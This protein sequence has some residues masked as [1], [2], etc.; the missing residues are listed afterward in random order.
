MRKIYRH[1]AAIMFVSTILIM[2]VVLKGSFGLPT[3]WYT[4]FTYNVSENGDAVVLKKYNGSAT[5]VTIPATVS[6]DGN[7]YDVIVSGGTTTGALFSNNTTLT[8]VTFENGVKADTSLNYL[9]FG[10]SSLEEIVFNNFDTSATTSMHGMFQG[11]SSLKNLDLSHLNT[12]NV[13]DM[14]SMFQNCSGLEELNISN[15]NTS[16]VTTMGSMFNGCSSLKNL[17]VSSFNTSNVTNMSSMFS[18]VSSITTLDVSNFNTSNVT[19]M[20]GMFSALRSV[21][22]L[23]LSNFN[24]SNVTTMN[25]MFQ[26]CESLESVN[27]SSFNTSNV[28]SMSQMFYKCNSLKTLDLS[29]FSTSNVTTM[30]S[31]FYECKAL[32]TLDMSSFTSESLTSLHNTFY[33]TSNLSKIHIGH[34]S[35]LYGTEYDKEA[36]NFGR[37]MW[38]RLEDGKNYE[39]SERLEKSS[40]EDISGTYVFVSSIADSMNVKYPVQYKIEEL[41]TIDETYFS[42]DNLFMMRNNGLY[43]KNLTTASTDDYVV[44]GNAT[45]L[46]KN[47]V[48]DL[49]NNSYHLKITVDNIHLYD[50]NTGDYSEP[51][52]HS[53]IGIANKGITIRS[54]SYADDFT[55]VVYGKS[56]SKYDVT[57]EIVD[58]AGVAQEGS[59]IFSVRD[60]DIP[61]TR[62]KTSTYTYNDDLGWGT[63]SEGIN[64]I[65]GFDDSTLKTYQYSKLVR[66]GNRIY[67]NRFDEGSEFSEFSIKVDAHKFK[68]AWTGEDCGTMTIRYYQPI[69]VNIAKQDNFNHVLEGAEL[70]LYTIDNTLV[71][72]W[73]STSDTHKLFLNAGHYILKEKT[74]PT[75]Y[76]KASD[77]EF[78][79]DIDG[80][81]VINNNEDVEGIILKD[82]GKNVK[83]IVKYLV[84]GTNEELDRITDNNKEFGSSYTSS[85]KS[86]PG[87]VLTR[88]PESETVVLD[89]DETVLTYYYKK[90]SGGV[91]EKHINE[92][93]GAILY[94][95]VHNGNVGDDYNISS[96]TFEGLELVTSRLPNNSV[97]KMQEEIIEVIYYY[98]EKG[99]IK[100][101]YVDKETNEEISPSDIINGYVNDD[102]SSS[103]KD[104]P[105][106][107]YVNVDGEPIGKIDKENQDVIY[108]YQRVVYITTEVNGSGG[109]ISGDETVYYHH[110][111]T[112]NNIIIE[113]DEE[114]FINKITINGEEIKIT[115]D[116]K[117]VLANFLN[118]DENKHIVVEF[119]SIVPDV[120]KTDI[121]TILPFVGIG[122]FVLGLIF[123]YLSKKKKVI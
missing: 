84:E 54:Y 45:L 82:T 73:T 1:L 12:S 32:Q 46:I 87:Y 31:M 38:K 118:M 43:L 71:D 86:F 100:I 99:S 40:T 67:G 52:Y 16:N 77:L 17:N 58:D 55:T 98:K 29:S 53:V 49:N 101:K 37:G 119:E 61:S 30:A 26:S 68:F 11:C 21:T 120:P 104:I 85:A 44:P 121:Y 3:D 42:D 94:N 105:Q 59:Y 25:R 93:T 8:K 97:G 65:D 10:C 91:L 89:K 64:L 62:D 28:T 115:N 106:Y 123:I 117:M 114:H 14:Y 90:I 122:T 69:F 5:E 13:T 92:T 72:T 33:A 116:N 48:K 103:S 56:S 66:D 79:V 41:T 108:Y 78:Y 18:N 76:N 112:E 2:A 96:K 36:Y 80:N 57:F 109:N 50:I 81:I 24:T 102:Y 75:N 88:S 113:A 35:F 7:D 6:I 83:V 63:H 110:D 27:L 51:F 39:I 70:E 20:A 60:I 19:N 23:N 15:F 22:T 47:V 4:D 95:E 74:P 34:F 9:F 107:I 111:S